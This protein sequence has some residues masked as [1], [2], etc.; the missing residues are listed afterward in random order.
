MLFLLSTRPSCCD[1]N[2]NYFLPLLNSNKVLLYNSL[3]IGKLLFHTNFIV[4]LLYLSVYLLNVFIRSIFMLVLLVSCKLLETKHWPYATWSHCLKPG[5]LLWSVPPTVPKPDKMS[6]TH[7]QSVMMTK[8]KPKNRQVLESHKLTY[9][10]PESLTWTKL[11][12]IVQI[13]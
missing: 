10:Y 5:Q 6:W 12:G 8:W 4:I 1:L 7:T 9:E 2:L 13:M 11:F 3:S